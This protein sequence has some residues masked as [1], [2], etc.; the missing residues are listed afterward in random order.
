MGS[1]KALLQEEFGQCFNVVGTLDLLNA[2]YLGIRY[3]VP[4][5]LG[6]AWYIPTVAVP[7]LLVSHAMIFARLAR[8][9]P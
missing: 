4:P 9:R 1:G 2:L 5:H 3:R 6:S 7:A 8:R